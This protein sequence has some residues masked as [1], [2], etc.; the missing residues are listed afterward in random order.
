MTLFLPDVNVR[1][2]LSDAPH[3]HWADSS[4][5]LRRL[6]QDSQVIFCRYTPLGLLRLLT[7]QTVMGAETLTLQQAWSVNDQWLEDPRIDMHP[8]PHGLEEG[9][10]PNDSATRGKG[11]IKMGWRLLPVGLCPR[12]RR[13]SRDIRKGAS[14]I[15]AE[16]RICRHFASLMRLIETFRW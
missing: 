14:G 9:V 1:V 15:G 16:E 5:W 12:L 11:R 2:A 4:N 6:T 10:S 3:V 13:D 7:N 8:E